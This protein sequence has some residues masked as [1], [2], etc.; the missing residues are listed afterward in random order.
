VSAAQAQA[1][2]RACARAWQRTQPVRTTG[3]GGR[4]GERE[5]ATTAAHTHTRAR[6]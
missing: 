5:G 4:G 6:A 1:G 2:R 3:G